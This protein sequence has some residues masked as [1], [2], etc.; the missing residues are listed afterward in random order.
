MAISFDSQRMREADDS[1]CEEVKLSQIGM[2]R[3]PA[4]VSYECGWSS[5]P[6]R[7]NYSDSRDER[8]TMA[9]CGLSV[10]CDDLH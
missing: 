6:D 1:I 8:A 10:G 7:C 5:Y 9:H 2:Q 3:K 4:K